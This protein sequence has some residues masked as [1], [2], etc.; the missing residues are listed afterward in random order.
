MDRV[1]SWL[2]I[3]REVRLLLLPDTFEPGVWGVWR[4]IVLMPESMAEQLDDAELEAVMMHEMIHVAR[5]D[6]LV[7]NLHRLLCC[8]FWFHPIVW[9]LD[10]LL[11]GRAWLV[12]L[13]SALIGIVTL[14]LTLLKL[15][16]AVG[17]ALAKQAVLQRENASLS[18]ENSEL[19]ATDRVQ[20]RAAQMGMEFATSRALRSLAANAPVDLRRGALALS[21]PARSSSTGSE[22][23]GSGGS[24]AAGSS[25]SGAEGARAEAPGGEAPG[26]GPSGAS[27]QAGPQTGAEAAPTEGSTAPASGE[28]SPSPAAQAPAGPGPSPSPAGGTQARPNG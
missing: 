1:R 2:G 25:A 6:N 12:L 23:A 27:S 13:T 24:A 17:R 9:L 15:N 11:R 28:A 16:G 22:E 3:K 8:L 4:P 5:W 18:I 21:A 10:R 26:A 7:A 14:Q 19:A 20:A